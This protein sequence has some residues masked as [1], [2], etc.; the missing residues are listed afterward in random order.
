MLYKWVYSGVIARGSREDNIV[1]VV[2]Y[3]YLMFI[4]AACLSE[5]FNVAFL[6]NL[7]AV[8]FLIS[9]LRLAISRRPN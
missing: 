3:A 6:K 2:L 4:L 8:L 1:F 7:I 9:L 5:N